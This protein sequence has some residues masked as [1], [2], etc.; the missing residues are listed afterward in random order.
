MLNS[1]LNL[2]GSSKNYSGDCII[3]EVIWLVVLVIGIELAKFVFDSRDG[4]EQGLTFFK[5]I[6]ERWSKM[7]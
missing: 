6:E 4:I 3:Q 1:T 2:L 5:L 7:Y